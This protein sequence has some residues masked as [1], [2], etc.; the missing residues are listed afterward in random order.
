[1]TQWYEA[2]FANYGRTYDTESYTQGTVGE[3]DFVE[4][5]LAADR[6]KRILDIGCGTGRH[7]I[8]LA[9]RGYRVTGFDLSEAQLRRA[10]EKAAEAGVVVEFE[11][12]DATQPHFDREFDAAIMFCEGAFS[13]M[14][15]DEKNYAIL[16]HA[17]AALRPGGKLLMTTLNALFPLFHSVKDFLAANAT[18]GTATDKVTFDLITFRECAELTFTDDAGQP[19]T[20]M[21]NER[22]YTPS[23]MRWLLQTAGFIKVDILGCHLGKFSREDALTP[24]DFEMLVVAVKGE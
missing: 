13:L 6:T 4:R 17:G 24:D 9:R 8:E 15:T 22:Y 12:R 11:R 21:T 20:I 1:M 14:E 19:R 3:V 18:G 16:R 23:E 2:L 10:R 7:A 5:E